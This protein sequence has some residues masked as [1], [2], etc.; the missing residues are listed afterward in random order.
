MISERPLL[1]F[2][3]ILYV[4]VVYLSIRALVVREQGT[5]PMRVFFKEFSRLVKLRA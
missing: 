5:V 2:I 4:V 3:F 1:I